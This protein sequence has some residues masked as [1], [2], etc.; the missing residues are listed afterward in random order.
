LGMDSFALELQV[1][2]HTRIENTRRN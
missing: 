2:R 1:T